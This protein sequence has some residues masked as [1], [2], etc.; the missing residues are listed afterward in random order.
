M[1]DHFAV[2]F[3]THIG[4]VF[5][6]QLAFSKYL[7]SKN[8]ARIDYEK[9]TSD[10]GDGRIFS[11]QLLGTQLDTEDA[12][13]WAWADT[14]EN[15]PAKLLLKSQELKAL[16]EAQHIDTLAH[17]KQVLELSTVMLMPDEFNGDHIA[18]VAAGVFNTIYWREP[19]DEGMLF[20][21]IST[22][23][24]ELMGPYPV[25][26]ILDTLE[27]V[28]NYYS[29]DNKA[30]VNAFLTQQGFA[31]QWSQT[32]D[33]ATALLGMR[34]TETIRA[35]FDD[36]E[37]LE[38]LEAHGFEGEDQYQQEAQEEDASEDESAWLLPGLTQPPAPD[39]EFPP[40]M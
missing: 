25:P 24:A 7:G 12:W 11:I 40:R 8:Q 18:S 4:T 35:S 33:G 13:V 29:T 9:G 20:Y 1:Q 17:P 31:T 28:C 23:P 27:Q 6:R 26:T 34:D 10:F 16:G 37:V 3:D 19:T 21:I 36:D 2:L 39:D 5:A 14:S 22:P 38:E 30:M 32:D 15:Y